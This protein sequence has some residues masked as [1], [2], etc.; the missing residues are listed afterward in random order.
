[1]SRCYSS[2]CYEDRDSGRLLRST[3]GN[4]TTAWG[5]PGPESARTPQHR[6]GTRIVRGEIVTVGIALVL[7]GEARAAVHRQAV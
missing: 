7:A 3:S 2:P 6:N 5:S 1:M 4:R